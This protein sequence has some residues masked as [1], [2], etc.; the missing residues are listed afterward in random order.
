MRRARAPWPLGGRLAAVSIA[1]SEAARVTV[2]GAAMYRRWSQWQN[3]WACQQSAITARGYSCSGSGP[4]ASAW[5]AERRS[6]VGF[7]GRHGATLGVASFSTVG[8]GCDCT[9]VAA[10]RVDG[11]EARRAALRRTQFLRYR[12]AAARVSGFQDGRAP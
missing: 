2:S 10:G 8:T 3:I 9:G 12:R 11:Q 6:G 7:A 4:W 5:T 1:C